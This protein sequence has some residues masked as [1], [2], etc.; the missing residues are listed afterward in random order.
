MLA[1]DP[2]SQMAIHTKVRDVLDPFLTSLPKR[3]LDA[4]AGNGYLTEWLLSRGATVT[5]FDISSED[6]R[7]PSV[8]CCYS[9]FDQGLDADD[10][11]FDVSVSIETIEHLENPFHF[12]RELGRVTKPNGAI[13][14]TTPNV[15]SIRSRIK[16]LFC[17]MPTLFEYTADD[18]MGQHISPVSI[19]Q[20]LYAFKSANLMLTDLYTTGPKSSVFVEGVLRALDR[21]T[22]LGLG[23]IRSSRRADL[24]HFLNVLPP[25]KIRELNRD[26]SLIVVA[27]KLQ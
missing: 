4:A 9:D 10:N 18:H 13:I 6:W 1:T 19:G 7:V 23:A 3:V 14:I 11:Y 22:A 21:L 2:I 16:Y 17:G 5:P 15:H 25:E 8:Q 12:I 27:K 24:D 26:V 20:F